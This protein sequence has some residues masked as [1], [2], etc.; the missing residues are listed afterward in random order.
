MENK[1]ILPMV[2]Q[3]NETG[4][5]YVSWKVVESLY[6]LVRYQHE[7]YK[8][9]SKALLESCKKKENGFLAWYEDTKSKIDA[10][11]ERRSSNG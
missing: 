4:E 6:N 1:K 11:L 2:A 3:D 9:R 8:N 5:I 7:F 10:E